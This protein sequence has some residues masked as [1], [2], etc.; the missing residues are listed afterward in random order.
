MARKLT[1]QISESSLS[2]APEDLIS[3]PVKVETNG[4][5]RKA[6]AALK[7]EDEAEASADNDEA[8][9]KTEKAPKKKARVEKVAGRETVVKKRAPVKRQSKKEANQAPLEQRTVGSKLRVGAHVSTAGGTY[10]LLPS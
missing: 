4:R 7:E 5:K 6:K 10:T 8:A 9:T 1:K 3:L 2:S